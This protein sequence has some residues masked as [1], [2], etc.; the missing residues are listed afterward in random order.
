MRTALYAIILSFLLLTTGCVSG[1]VDDAVEAAEDK[2]Y[3]KWTE[4]W[5]PALMDKVEVELLTMKDQVIERIDEDTQAKFD[6][7]G[8]DAAS[9]DRNADGSLQ[10]DEAITLL[11]EMKAANDAQGNPYSILELM[12][13]FGV[14]YGG[15]SVL[16]GGVRM[17][18]KK[19]PSTEQAS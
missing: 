7:L 9:H 19:A 12:A 16:K 15:G 8:V 4:E 18:A 17:A 6:R 2:L 3:Q 11:A 1:M 10:A 5:S 13:A 14:V